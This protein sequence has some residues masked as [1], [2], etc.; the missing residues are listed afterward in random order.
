MSN[1]QQVV[2]LLIAH[3]TRTQSV[4]GDWLCRCGSFLCPPNDDRLD[5]CHREHLATLLERYCAAPVRCIC[6]PELAPAVAVN[7]RAEQHNPPDQPAR[8]EAER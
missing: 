4:E 8:P 7:C 6:L 2:D 5:A 1:R 3:D